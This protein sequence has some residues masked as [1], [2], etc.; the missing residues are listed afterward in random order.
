MNER[1][2]YELMQQLSEAINQALSDSDEV[3]K[4]IKA[5]HDNGCE[6]GIGMM[7]EV[8]AYAPRQAEPETTTPP[9]PKVK[10]G[11]VKPGTFTTK[12]ESWAKKF[13]IRLDP[14]EPPKK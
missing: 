13:K 12:N 8:I 11:R 1:K 6:I 7:A 5:F 14:E 4:A 10:D 9:E 2:L 3:G